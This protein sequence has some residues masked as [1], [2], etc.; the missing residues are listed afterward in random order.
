MPSDTQLGV[1]DVKIAD[2]G[3]AIFD[4]NRDQ[5]RHDLPS[6]FPYTPPEIVKL[7]SKRQEF[8][9]QMLQV[10]VRA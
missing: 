6:T 1:G 4:D 10:S 2:L 8:T 3:Y 7:R 5:A 9:Q